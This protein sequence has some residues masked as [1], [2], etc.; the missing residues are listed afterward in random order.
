MKGNLNQCCHDMERDPRNSEIQI[1]CMAALIPILKQEVDVDNFQRAFKCIDNAIKANT[2]NEEV[3]LQTLDLFLALVNC[4]QQHGLLETTNLFSQL[5]NILGIS[6]DNPRL[7]EQALLVTSQTISI[8]RIGSHF[9]SAKFIQ[10]LVHIGRVNSKSQIH[11]IYLSRIALYVNPQLNTVLKDLCNVFVVLSRNF[12]KSEELQEIIISGFAHISSPKVIEEVANIALPHFTDVA[13]RH[14]RNYRIFKGLLAISANAKPDVI[15]IQVYELTMQNYKNMKTDTSTLQQS[16]E[17]LATKMSPQST[18]LAVIPLIT[19][20]LTVF[21]SNTAIVK[22][23]LTVCFHGV[24]STEEPIPIAPKLINNLVTILL[25]HA[26]E[27]SLIRRVAAIIHALSA[28]DGNDTP[29]LQSTAAFALIQ[30]AS[31]NNKDQQTIHLISLALANFVVDNP[32]IASSINQPEQIKIIKSLMVSF[33]KKQSIVK[34]VLLILHAIARSKY[35]IREF[36]DLPSDEK[37]DFLVEGKVIQPIFES[38]L[39]DIELIRA[40]MLLLKKPSNLDEFIAAAM[41]KYGND[42]EIQYCGLYHEINDTS[43]INKALAIVGEKGLRY[44]IHS[45]NAITDPLPDQLVQ[46]LLQF[47][48]NDVIDLLTLHCTRNSGPIIGKNFHLQYISQIKIA[49][50]LA[51]N[52]YFTPKEEEY[53]I[54]LTSLYHSIYDQNQ[55]LSALNFAKSIGLTETS[56]PFLIEAI[57]KHAS[58]IEIVAICAEFISGFEANEQTEQCSIENHALSISLFALKVHKKKEEAVFALLK[59]FNFLASFGSLVHEFSSTLCIPLIL[60]VS[61][62][63]EQCLEECCKI[64]SKLS[65]DQGNCNILSNFDAEK[66]A[67]SSKFTVNSYQLI[68]NMMMYTDL[69][70]NS[71]QFEKVI[72][73]FKNQ[74]NQLHPDNIRYLFQIILNCYESDESL[75]KNLEFKILIPFI[76]NF[77]GNNEIILCIIRLL[78]FTDNYLSSPEL[79]F[80]LLE[81]LRAKVDVP[82]VAIPLF[83]TITQFYPI[84]KHRTVLS[85]PNSVELFLDLLKRYPKDVTVNINAFTLL[86]GDPNV[87]HYVTNSFLILKD[88]IALQTASSCLLSIA[89]QCEMADTVPIVIKI[90]KQKQN[91][92]EICKNLM[93]VVFYASSNN[94]S[95]TKLLKSFGLLSSILL[96]YVSNIMIARAMIGLICSLSEIPANTKYIEDAPMLIA[97][98]LKIW[99]SDQQIQ[100]ASA[101]AI[102]NFAAAGLGKAFIPLMPLLILS[103]KMR[104]H[105]DATCQSITSLSTNLGQLCL[106][107]AQELLNLISDNEEPVIAA[108]CLL[109][110]S[111]YK[112]V[113][114]FLFEKIL[115]VFHLLEIS[116]DDEKLAA[117]LLK[118]CANLNDP[119]KLPI[120]EPVIPNLIALVKHQKQKIATNAA[121]CLLTIA[122]YRPEMLDKYSDAI[123]KVSESASGELLRI[124]IQIKEKLFGLRR[125]K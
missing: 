48:R 75:E 113:K 67:F 2:Q 34:S 24:S 10:T 20:A 40:S 81:A 122:S 57:D 71:D 12:Y 27:L 110:I 4:R 19:I 62:L 61:S 124:S 65:N 17:L 66:I 3:I 63:S 16:I 86:R 114:D 46:F 42:K 120:F 111:H 39:G 107:F 98:I 15:P 125:K 72:D 96:R 74:K 79:L 69:N 123:M 112:A 84:E 58:N 18:P 14:S 35:G 104:I 50:E 22:Q 95:H 43:S 106:S 78:P 60:E 59:L 8:P 52:G 89:A 41:M 83:T 37:E 47:D 94:E 29:L 21:V 28:N 105:I 93:P 92:L 101:V 26:R 97:L 6:K 13:L 82:E 90:L 121:K 109:A 11:T 55:L 70:L 7:N 91:Q 117:N 102:S 85:S 33:R 45:L 116:L 118:I 99:H 119:E 25:M 53:P 31:M 44:A 32:T 54:I 38:Q 56:Y 100:E 108:K 49:K 103:L 36:L 23:A 30:V 51:E 88:D 68:Y 9:S 77:S 76:T 115:I 87:Y 64:C 80:D 1:K 5:I 73:E